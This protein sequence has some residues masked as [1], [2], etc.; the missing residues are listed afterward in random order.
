MRA[1]LWLYTKGKSCS[2]NIGAFH[3]GVTTSEEQ[4]RAMDVASLVFPKAFGTVVHT[5]L[6]FKLDKEGFDG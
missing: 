3:D 2:T 6:L 5:L 4:G 1:L